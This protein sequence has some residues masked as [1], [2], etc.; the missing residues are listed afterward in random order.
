MQSLHRS[1]S[2]CN[3]NN[4]N[5][6]SYKKKLIEQILRFHVE[7]N[8][9]LHDPKLE[10]LHDFVDRILNDK[11][12][13]LIQKAEARHR[14]KQRSPELHKHIRKARE[15]HFI[16]AI[17]DAVMCLSD[18]LDT[19]QKS[20]QRLSFSDLAEK[21]ESALLLARVMDTLIYMKKA[22]EENQ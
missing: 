20:L 19:N 2:T 10:N 8:L 11:S 16:K 15:K 1:R 9:E 13:E 12:N 14:L 22:R 18:L 5:Q 4:Q 6:S 7:V 21:Q 3:T 17:D